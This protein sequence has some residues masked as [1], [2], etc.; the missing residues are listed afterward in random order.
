MLD[1][2]RYSR[3]KATVTHEKKGRR[4]IDNTGLRFVRHATSS[5]QTVPRSSNLWLQNFLSA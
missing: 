5:C 4:H 2:Q 1:E 3:K